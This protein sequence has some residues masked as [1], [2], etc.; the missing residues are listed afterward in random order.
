MPCFAVPSC[1]ANCTFIGNDAAEERV[2]V[3]CCVRPSV[4]GVA[5]LMLTAGPSWACAEPWAWQGSVA[6]TVTVYGPGA[7]YSWSSWNVPSPFRASCS[8]SPPSP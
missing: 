6:V 5:S 3:N 2:T 1:V 7:T 8:R 4:T